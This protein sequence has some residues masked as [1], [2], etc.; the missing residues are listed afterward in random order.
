MAPYPYLDEIHMLARHEA[1]HYVAARCLGFTAGDIKLRIVGCPEIYEGTTVCLPRHHGG[2]Y[3]EAT[4]HLR[5][6]EKVVDW[7]ER[8]IQVL[9]AGS[10]AQAMESD[11]VDRDLAKEILKANGSADM[12][13]INHFMALLRNILHPVDVLLEQIEPAMEALSQRLW[14][15]AIALVEREASVI[16]GLAEVVARIAI[17]YTNNG[18]LSAEKIQRLEVIQKRFGG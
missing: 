12:K 17:H 7:L 8:R 3:I 18:V 4:E 6:V 16:K 11:S 9:Y 10:L 5:T 13:A 2:C 1:G 14:E 15:H